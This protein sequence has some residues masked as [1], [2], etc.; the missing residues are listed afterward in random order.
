MGSAKKAVNSIVKSAPAALVGGLPGVVIDKVTGGKLSGLINEQVDK[1]TPQYDRTI[2]ES[3]AP[4]LDAATADANARNAALGEQIKAQQAARANVA[5]PQMTAERIDRSQIQNIGASNVGPGTAVGMDVSGV[6]RVSAQT[7]AQM[8]RNAIQNVSALSGGQMDTS[9]I[10][11]VTSTNTSPME[12]ERIARQNIQNANAL[13]SERAATAQIQ[14]ADQAQ[15]RQ[16]QLALGAQLAAQAAGTAPSVA[17]MQAKK[18]GERALAAQMAMQAGSSG[19]TAPLAQRTAARNQASIGADIANQSAVLRLQEQQAAQKALGDLAGQVRTQDI[20][21]AGQQAQLQ[22][23]AN[24]A[25]LQASAGDVDRQLRANLANQGV[26]LD[27]L[28]SNAAAG[29]Q[30]AI[31]NLAAATQNADRDVRAQMANQ[32]TTTDISKANLQANISDADRS[33]RAQ[34]ANQAADV[35]VAQSNLQAQVADFD[36][37]L[38][39]SL[40]NQGVDLDKAKMDAANGNAMA[41]ANLQVATQNADRLLKADLA[42][43]GVDLEVLKANAAA[44]NAAAQANLAASL[45]KMGLDDQMSRA[46]MQNQLD[47]N[48]QQTDQIMQSLAIQSQE[49]IAQAGLDAQRAGAKYGQ[50]NQN[51]AGLVNTVATGAAAFFSDEN[52]K[53][54]ITKDEEEQKKKK[55]EEDKTSKQKFADAL[56]SIGAQDS[57]KKEQKPQSVYDGIGKIGEALIKKY[58]SGGADTQTAMSAASAAVG[59]MSDE[60]QKDGKSK[61][62]GRLKDMLDNLDVY[63]YDYKDPKFGEGRQTSVMAQDL[64][65]S[66]IGKKAIIETPEG[67]MV[68]YAKLM[69]S[70]L[71]ANVDAHKRI[72]SLEEA[73]KAKK[74][75]K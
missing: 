62:T 53:M 9:G 26:D 58:A 64:E 69:P 33:V 35:T 30:A 46:Y 24:L 22:Q 63:S 45:Q 16:Q 70:M 20:S 2:I 73:L 57:V 21:L 56:K 29:N 7:G 14:T 18:A 60:Q 38:R 1:L 41:L 66:A 17:E 28:K 4:K 71:A 61:Q 5:T 48:K 36:R 39:A 42:N 50:A 68:D 47:L 49:K 6:Q 34:M 23:S 27:V 43:Q 44:G 19:S 32:A 3:S 59:S 37:S 40:A 54:N 8:D 51:V 25:N 72:T 15:A 55:D 65:K 74:G 12:A 31:A 52:L 67:K 10:N 75:K 11:A 13:N